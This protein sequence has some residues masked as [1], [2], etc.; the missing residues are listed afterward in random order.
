MEGRSRKGDDAYHPL[1]PCYAHDGE[2]DGHEHDKPLDSCIIV[3]AD[4]GVGLS[5]WNKDFGLKTVIKILNEKIVADGGEKYPHLVFAEESD[6]EVAKAFGVKDANAEVTPVGELCYRQGGCQ[7][8]KVHVEYSK[9]EDLFEGDKLAV[10]E[11]YR[12]LARAKKDGAVL[13]VVSRNAAS[14]EPEPMDWLW[15]QR[16]PAYT[17]NWFYGAQGSAKSAATCEL[18]AIVSTGRDWPDG[19]ANTMGACKVFLY[20]AEDDVKR[21]VIPRLIAAE[22]DLNNIEILDEKS[23][24]ELTGEGAVIKRSIDLSRDIPILGHM[25][26]HQ[27]G[28][29]VLI[30]DPITGIWGSKDVNKDKEIVGI[31]EKLKQLCE[32][33][34][35]TFIGVSHTNKRSDV[36]ALEKILGSSSIS[37]KARSAWFFSQD[38]ESDDKHD[39]KM[40]W[41]KGNLS[42]KKD[43]MNF[44]TVPV[45]LTFKGKEGSYPKIHWLETTETDAND[46]M[47]MSREKRGAKDGKRTAAKQFIKTML[48][49]GPMKSFDI[50]EMAKGAGMQSETVKKAAQDLTEERTIIRRQKGGNWWM[51]LPQHADQFSESEKPSKEGAIIDAEVL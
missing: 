11:G 44:R 9:P 20:N 47:A 33:R 6:E 49:A 50:Y 35:I 30:C 42:E 7:C 46:V 8:G 38:P 25:L 21:T 3:F 45:T 28:F 24:R 10:E 31:L 26:N 15:S 27:E 36:S 16:I 48:A 32:K 39:H 43:G 51:L 40:V 1:T 5:C 12:E 17:I 14:I 22:A 34:R 19:E 13:Q 37:G 2:L 18:A 4:G 23:F 29:A 41:A